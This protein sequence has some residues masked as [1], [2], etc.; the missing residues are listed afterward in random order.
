MAAPV[1]AAWL[2]MGNK[3]ETRAAARATR[4]TRR[5]LGTRATKEDSSDSRQKG[6][7]VPRGATGR[8]DPVN[9]AGSQ[10]KGREVRERNATDCRRWG[11]S[12]MANFSSPIPQ[13]EQ[14]LAQR[15]QMSHIKLGTA[16]DRM[17]LSCLLGGSRKR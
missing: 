6:K 7:R 17:R 11:R 12:R 2:V 10:P 16:L 9:G 4:E 14:D 1:W 15:Q 5:V 3:A 8:P 13:T